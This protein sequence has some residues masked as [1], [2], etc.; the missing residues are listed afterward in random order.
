MGHH[1]DQ[2]QLKLQAGELKEAVAEGVTKALD[3]ASD[4]TRTSIENAKPHFFKAAR[5]TL[6]AAAP[7]ID[8]A[9]TQ[10]VKMTESTADALGRFQKDMLDEYLPR[11]SQAIEDAAQKVS[12][13]PVK[14]EE[15]VAAVEK[16]IRPKKKHRGRKVVMWTLIGVGVAGVGYL[17]WR[18]SQ[19]IEDPWAEEYWSDLDNSD[20]DDNDTSF[21]QDVVDQVSDKAADLADKAS[22][23][24]DKVK[25]Q[26]TDN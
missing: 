8:S 20:K 4:F 19:P 26:V 15:K 3:S 6:K 24:A 1:I 2:D 5:G 17:L 23:V 9:G 11:M 13:A 7:I 18:R 16:K 12:G 25:D 21:A 10:A 22:D 14:V